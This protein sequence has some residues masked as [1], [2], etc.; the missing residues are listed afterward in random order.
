MWE[1]H[2]FLTSVSLALFKGFE[3]ED[4]ANRTVNI[5]PPT[6]QSNTTCHVGHGPCLTIKFSQ[7]RFLL[8]SW[9]SR[10]GRKGGPSLEH[11]GN[12]LHLAGMSSGRV[13]NQYRNYCTKGYKLHSC[14][15]QL[16]PYICSCKVVFGLTL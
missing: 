1:R 8:G 7:E 14:C 9:R 4:T 5:P 10:K 2:E 3:E 11:A 13:P 15:P 16:Q 12:P 6:Y